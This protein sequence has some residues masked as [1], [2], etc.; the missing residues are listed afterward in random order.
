MSLFRWL[1]WGSSKTVS[2]RELDAE[3]RSHMQHRADD[4]ERSGLPRTEAERRARVE[5]GGYVRFKEE[6]SE[7]LGKNWIDAI[8]HDVRYSARM[9]RKSPGFSIAAVITLALG[10][11]ANAVVFSVLNALIL[12]PLDLPGSQNLYTIDQGRDHTP[13]QS[14]L[15][16]KDLRDR[17]H[18]FDGIV[19]YEIAP[20]GLTVDGNTTQMWPYEVSE[21]Y[22]DVLGV[23]PYLGRFFHASDEH[24]YNS[25]PYIVLSYA[26][27]KS[28][29]NGDPSVVGRAVQ[30]NKNPFTIVGVAPPHFRG[31]ELFYS[32]DLWV[33][34]VDEGQVEGGSCLDERSCRGRWLVGR[35]K[36]GVTVAQANADLQSLASYLQKTYP[37]DDD[38]IQFG[39]VR[40]GLLGDMLGGPVRAFMA[41]LMLLAGLILLGACANLGALFAARAAD[42]AREV[43]L[44]LALGS[45]RGRILRQ[46]LCEAVLVALAGGVAGTFGGIFLLRWLSVWQPVPNIP[47]NVAVQPD[48]MTYVMALMLAVV[49]G[50]LFGAVPMRQV[51]KADPYQIVKAGIAGANRRRVT[52]RDVLVA[53]QIAVCAVLVTASLVAVRGMVRSMR[54]SFGFDPNN[55]YQVHTDL[56]MVGYNG[57]QIPVVQK[58]ILDA[59]A[60]VPGVKDIAFAD[61]VPL[62]LG[63]SDSY[64]Y[65][66]LTT[67]YRSSSAMLDAMQYSVSPGYFKAASTKVLAGREISWHDD[68]KAPKAAV[69]NSEFARKAFGSEQKAIGSFFKLWGGMRVQVV[70]VVETGKYKTLAEDPQPAM[71]LS[72]LQNPT[73]D[74]WMVVRSNRDLRELG[75]AIEN[76][77]HGIDPGL[78]LVIDPWNRE[79]DSALFAPRAATIALG[80]L[81]A[82]GAMLAVTGIFGMAS[83][84]VSKRLRELGIR[85]ALGAQKREVLSTALGRALRLLAIGSLA[86]LGLGIA[87]S[88]VLASIVYQATPRDPVVLIGVVATMLLLGLVATWIPASRAL[89]ADPL[90]L[91]RED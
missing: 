84:S 11:G 44:R 77:A 31:S 36:P 60:G 79:L 1:R 70:G 14:Y 15:D 8:W 83:Y 48:A 58:R 7:A 20:A 26:Y 34:M 78:P 55:A 22:F 74:M 57:D 4:L 42:R 43:A 67:D 19:A 86:G 25:A 10:I 46:L 65:S 45:S 68:M 72:I 21:N 38:K 16:Y 87:A 28:H 64:V 89:R 24:G 39:L 54:S 5:F 91:L 41:G 66:D 73:S 50:L 13:S 9:L 35:L 75:P 59:V 71:F 88:Q 40:P 85:I 52:L 63:W 23:K 2:D 37:K 6:S 27:W 33:P 17:T 69:V 18:S 3:M 49:S 56:E 90:L 53:G 76:A 81:G 32:P 30:V 12:R 29:F 51:L 82:L 47:I 80:V 62:D 61:R